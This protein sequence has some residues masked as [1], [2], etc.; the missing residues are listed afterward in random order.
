MS[1]CREDTTSYKAHANS[2]YSQVDNH[3]P[4]KTPAVDPVIV[5]RLITRTVMT[6]LITVKILERKGKT[7]TKEV[8]HTPKRQTTYK[9]TLKR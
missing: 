7:V 4:Q 1:N 5:R 9:R 2:T 3:P 6:S 8:Y